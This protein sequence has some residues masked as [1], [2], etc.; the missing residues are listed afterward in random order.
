MYEDAL[1]AQV[2]DL[3]DDRDKLTKAIGDLLT[4]IDS[5]EAFEQ[6]PGLQE[7]FDRLE[8]LL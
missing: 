8:R 7:A 6:F 3:R 4:L 1:E 2:A 5:A